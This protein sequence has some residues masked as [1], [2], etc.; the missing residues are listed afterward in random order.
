MNLRKLTKAD[1][2]LEFAEAGSGQTS[3]LNLQKLPNDRLPT[4]NLR[5]FPMA[6]FR[7]EFAEAADIGSKADFKF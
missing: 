2:R 4:F 7:L 1:F 5:K 3:D 6:D